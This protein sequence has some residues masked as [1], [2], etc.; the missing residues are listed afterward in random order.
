MKDLLIAEHPVPIE[1]QAERSKLDQVKSID[2]ECVIHGWWQL[3]APSHHH[4]FTQ[5][6]VEEGERRNWEQ[7]RHA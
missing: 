6:L 1:E 7:D 2:T 5:P 4:S 3:D